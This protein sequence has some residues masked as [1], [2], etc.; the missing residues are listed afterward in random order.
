M[1][2]HEENEFFQPDMT[3][4]N[5]SNCGCYAH[6]EY[7]ECD[8]RRC[9]QMPCYQECN[10]CEQQMKY[11]IAQLI[12]FYPTS[13]FVFTMKDVTTTTGVPTDI[14]D[15][16]NSGLLTVSMSEGTAYVNICKIAYISIAGA[17]YNNSTEYMRSPYCASCR[18]CEE[19]VR[20]Y[21]DIDQNVL[22]TIAGNT[23]D[24]ATVKATAPGIVALQTTT[25][26]VFASVCAID[27][28]VP[29]DD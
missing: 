16:C 18:G 20:D 28:I 7:C 9:C 12:E 29:I 25:A 23:L 11:L 10:I 8:C 4:Y 1:S 13:T 24:S 19:S 21:F 15:E 27:R 17:G 2:C 3:I 5:G 26:I 14:S 6:E 22:V